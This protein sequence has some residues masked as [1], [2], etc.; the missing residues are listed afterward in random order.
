MKTLNCTANKSVPLRK[1][2]WRII[3]KDDIALLFWWY[4]EIRKQHSNVVRLL[5]IYTPN[6][7][8]WHSNVWHLI[9]QLERHA[10]SY[11]RIETTGRQEK[12]LACIHMRSN[13]HATNNNWY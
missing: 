13:D 12:A 1:G 4:F 8:D 11:K 6:L 2:T 9:D 3:V 10:N 7:F 5:R